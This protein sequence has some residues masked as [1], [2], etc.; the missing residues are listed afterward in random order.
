MKYK[1]LHIAKLQELFT[2]TC[3]SIFLLQSTCNEWIKIQVVFWDLK[4]LY[5]G[6]RSLTEYTIKYL[7]LSKLRHIFN[8]K[9]MT[10]ESYLNATKMFL[11]LQELL[12]SWW[13][14][15]F[16]MLSTSIY[17][18]IFFIISLSTQ[19]ITQTHTPKAWYLNRKSINGINN[20]ISTNLFQNLPYKKKNQSQKTFSQL[21]VK[22]LVF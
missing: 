18:H 6:F 10:L 11:G 2:F 3:V 17:S 20:A 16:Q 19:N 1:N 14:G 22:E 15:T 12:S 21:T 9:N 4:S 5:H 8:I 7:W 13:E